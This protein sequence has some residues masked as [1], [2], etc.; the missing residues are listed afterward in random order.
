M[1]L[2]G[3]FSKKTKLSLHQIAD[4]SLNMFL[5]IEIVEDLEKELERLTGSRF[6]NYKFHVFIPCVMCRL[7]F[8]EVKYNR[9]YIMP[10]NTMHRFTD[11][12]LFNEIMDIASKNF[13]SYNPDSILKILFH[14]P[15]FAAINNALKGGADLNDLVTKPM[16]VGALYR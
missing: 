5:N 10:D 9:N 15:E 14:S 11:S 6:D 1:G 4:R 2:F 8:P 7:F 13:H 3:L 16:K 12:E